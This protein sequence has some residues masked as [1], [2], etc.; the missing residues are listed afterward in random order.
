M[1]KAPTQTEVDAGNIF[2]V[3]EQDVTN[4]F[5]PGATNTI[6]VVITPVSAEQVAKI[7]VGLEFSQIVMNTSR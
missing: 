3:F 4:S 5:Y 7:I 6:S 2:H 1:K